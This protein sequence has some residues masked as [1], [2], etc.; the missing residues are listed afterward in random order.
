L[1]D[2]LRGEE[3][4]MSEMAIW[5]DEAKRYELPYDD[6]IHMLQTYISDDGD[7]WSL[8]GFDGVLRYISDDDEFF[9][10]LTITFADGPRNGIKVS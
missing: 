9:N 4:Q 3:I 8:I 5:N 2:A 6:G 10:G 7:N 1:E